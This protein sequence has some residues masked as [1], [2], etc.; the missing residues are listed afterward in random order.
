LSALLTDSREKKG[1]G[2]KGKKDS[3]FLLIPWHK[4][5]TTGAEK[6]LETGLKLKRGRG[7]A[8]KRYGCYGVRSTGNEPRMHLLTVHDVND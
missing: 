3:C 7:G 5:F 8:E 1:E 6:T 2:K 4:R